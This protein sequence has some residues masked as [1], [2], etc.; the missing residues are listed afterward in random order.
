MRADGASSP[1][2]QG[3]GARTLGPTPV[4]RPPPVEDEAREGHEL[5]R[6]EAAHHAR[7]SPLRLSLGL[8]PMTEAL[9]EGNMTT[10]D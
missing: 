9:E 10:E 4:A 5:L 2:S 6:E 3:A 7:C 8:E 1:A